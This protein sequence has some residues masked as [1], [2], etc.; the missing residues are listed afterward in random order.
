M[1]A[2][3]ANSLLCRLALGRDLI[4]PVSFTTVRIACGAVVLAAIVLVGPAPRTRARWRT[5]ASWTSA[6]ALFAYAI[7]FSL[8]Y[9]SLEAGTG[10]L[11]LFGAVQATMIGWGLRTGERPR[12]SE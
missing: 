9:V 12:P 4:D 10:A 8:A 3:A 1:V 6:A 7:G 11:L 5:H 2:F